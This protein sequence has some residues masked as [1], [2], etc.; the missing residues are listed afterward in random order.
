MTKETKPKR[1]K[2]QDKSHNH[3]P[4]R[5]KYARNGVLR[6]AGWWLSALNDWVFEG[7]WWL[8]CAVDQTVSVFVVSSPPSLQGRLY[9]FR[10]L[11]H[12]L[13]QLS[14]SQRPPSLAITSSQ[15]A[16]TQPVRVRRSCLHHISNMT[17]PMRVRAM[18]VCNKLGPDV[19]RSL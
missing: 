13:I 5:Y 3:S 11:R 10:L 19:Y 1:N 16:S 4:R 14:N 2:T 17:V 18:F 15:H 6:G 9:T 12:I 7:N 8:G